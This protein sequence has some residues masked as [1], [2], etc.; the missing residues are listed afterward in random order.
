MTSSMSFEGISLLRLGEGGGEIPLSVWMSAVKVVAPF[1]KCSLAFEWEGEGPEEQ[2]DGLVF[3]LRHK[4]AGV[5][6][7]ILFLLLI[8]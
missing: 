3:P 6:R 8:G 1:F 7:W 2:I 5:G 4:E